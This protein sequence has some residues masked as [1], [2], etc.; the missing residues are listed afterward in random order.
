VRID[1]PQTVGYYGGL[2]AALA[3]GLLEAAAKPSPP[4]RR[5]RAATV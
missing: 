3:F 5:G 4:E 1:G 2:G